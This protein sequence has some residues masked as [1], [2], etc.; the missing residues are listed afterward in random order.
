MQSYPYSFASVNSFFSLVFFIH[1]KNTM[2]M[3]YVTKMSPHGQ[4][5]TKKISVSIRESLWK[6]ATEFAK[7]EGITLS[8]LIEI[9][10]RHRMDSDNNSTV[11]E[12]LAKLEETMKQ[13]ASK[14]K[15]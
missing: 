3:N 5:S 1:T 9:A 10:L 2:A 14:P 4:R 11:E 12:R 15:K 7:S 8:A 13:F 6:D